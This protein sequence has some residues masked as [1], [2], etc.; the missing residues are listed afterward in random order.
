MT[1]DI[2]LSYKREDETL[3]ARLAKALEASGLSVWW[4]RSLLPADS[5]RTQIQDAL[6][7]AR[8]VVVIWTREST[9]PRGDFVRD[10]AG[11]A[12]ARG[13]LIPVVMERTRLPLGFAEL[14]AIDL[15]GWRGAK[16]DVFFKD[17]LAAC[18]AKMNGTPPPPPRGPLQR[19]MR[20]AATGLASLAG[21]GAVL[22]FALNVMS[23]QDQLCTAPL[24]QPGFSDFCGSIGLGR[25]PTREERLAWAEITP[26]SCDA[27]RRHV[28]AFPAGAYAGQ[29]ADRLTARRVTETEV[30]TPATQ[31]LR[32]A[33]TPAGRGVADTAAAQAIA[34]SRATEDARILCSG[35]A[36]SS[37]RLKASTA[38]ID[39]WD[40][41]PGEAG[42]TCSGRG[43]AVCEIEKRGTVPAETCGGP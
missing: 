4:D 34:L 16:G 30:W 29:A 22:A 10:E 13:I 21:I 35:L 37:M 33:V 20:R 25:R 12:K 11:Q 9:G 2:F 24:A 40:C 17:L 36:G 23:V 3:A 5:W 41:R 43:E 38:R 14:Q 1:H 28:E 39:V 42:V 27:L 8:C 18:E 32:L 19:T 6:D 26:G 7:Q 31:P 15:T